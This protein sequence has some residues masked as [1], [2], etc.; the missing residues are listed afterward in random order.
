MS[1]T[2][3]TRTQVETALSELQAAAVLFQTALERACEE[4][5][6]CAVFAEYPQELPCVEELVAAL[7]TVDLGRDWHLNTRPV[8]ALRIGMKITPRPGMNKTIHLTGMKGWGYGHVAR[9]IQLSSGNDREGAHITC[10]PLDGWT[11]YE[12]F[13]GDSFVS[14]FGGFLEV[15][16]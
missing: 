3:Q 8:N 6:E 9:V 14:S 12:S 10:V 16:D 2:L 15:V 13:P 7:Q 5:A 11:P 1:V 4:Q